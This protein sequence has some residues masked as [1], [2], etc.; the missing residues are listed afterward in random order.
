MNNVKAV[1]LMLSVMVFKLP[2][3]V[4]FFEILNSELN[5]FLNQVQREPVV[6]RT[7]QIAMRLN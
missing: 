4:N 7:I 3:L 5:R 1:S 6:L 2:K